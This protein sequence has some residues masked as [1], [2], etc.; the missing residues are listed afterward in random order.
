MLAIPMLP[1]PMLAIPI[2]SIEERGEEPDMKPAWEL[3]GGRGTIPERG[4]NSG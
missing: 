3:I 1:I 4:G 2:P